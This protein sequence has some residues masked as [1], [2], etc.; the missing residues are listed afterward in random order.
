MKKFKM[1]NLICDSCELTSK[2]KLVAHYFI[3]KSNKKGECY[4][5][6]STI[7][8]KCGVSE[9]TI[10]RATKKLEEEGFITIIKRFFNGKQSSNEYKLNTLL[11]DELERN[12]DIENEMKQVSSQDDRVDIEIPFINF[13]D[14]LSNV[15]ENNNVDTPEIMQSRINKIDVNYFEY[16][17]DELDDLITTGQAIQPHLY[18]LPK[19]DFNYY[20]N[21]IVN[22]INSI[23]L[24]N[25]KASILSYIKIRILI[26]I[27]KILNKVALKNWLLNHIF[28]VRSKYI[29]RYYFFSYLGVSL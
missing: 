27:N 25:F 5:A 24:N 3:Y 28:I 21:I 11:I 23:F 18:P 12:K 20:I 13:V 14:E 7:A 19:H 16:D 6:V 1:L 9:R 29:F 4:P 15:E 8:S 2:E 26:Y 10:Q 17:Y 22:F